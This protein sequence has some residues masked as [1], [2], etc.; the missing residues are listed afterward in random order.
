MLDKAARITETRPAAP[1]PRPEQWLYWTGLEY[2][3]HGGTGVKRFEIWTRFDGKQ[4]ATMSNGKLVVSREWA[5]RPITDGSPVGAYRILAALPTDPQAMLTTLYRKVGSEW[6][7]EG[8]IG[9]RRAFENIKQLL[10]N[11]P[12]SPPPRVQAAMY[13]A[14]ARIPGVT[15]RTS[16][17]YAPG[18]T[19][20]GIYAPPLPN[21]NASVI[22]LD[23]A[24]Y[25]MIGMLGSLSLTRSSAI[26]V[27]RPGQR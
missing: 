1:V 24:T 15:V 13:R 21:H 18:R 3:Y 16:V 6:R 27:A 26:L 17:E 23:P 19:A 14:L 12:V 22:L 2:H 11:S 5:D 8:V 9:D 25:R 20:I 4:D 7:G 10:W